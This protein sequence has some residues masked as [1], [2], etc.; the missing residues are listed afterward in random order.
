[1]LALSYL[2]GSLPLTN[3]AA[4]R[5]SGVDLRE[6]GTG[7]VSGT[8]LYSVAGFGPLAVVGCMELAK[9]AAGPLLA[10]KERPLLA[11][12][13]GGCAVAGHD[14]SPFLRFSGGRGMAPAL[15]ASMV[16]A[17]EGTVLLG[18]GL[19]LGRLAGETAI[20]CFLSMVSMPFLLASRRG[21]IGAISGVSLA[22]P[23]LLK[24]IL[25]NG[26]VAA[27]RSGR[28]YAYRLL[29]DRDSLH[30]QPRSHCDG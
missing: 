16:V 3:I 8:G 6:V 2:V 28:V 22:L 1:V 29:L 23:M 9:G 20:G 4:R 14:W 25:G 7:T 13:A 30:E 12:A 10:G 27:S 21:P 17:P 26:P 19:G 11:A 15:G 24:R 18:A 5:V